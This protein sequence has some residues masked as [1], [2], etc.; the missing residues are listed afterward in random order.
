MSQAPSDSGRRP[1][2]AGQGAIPAGSG[3]EPPTLYAALDLGTNNCR[4]MIASFAHSQFRIVEAFSRIVRLGE[5]LAHSGRLQDRAM[6][7]AM[8]ALRI[9]AEKIEKRGVVRIRAVAT[10][11]CRIARN[12]RDF[13]SRVERE[14]GLKLSVISPEEEAHLS[15]M[16]CTSLLDGRDMTPA[17]RA[18]LVMDVGGGSTELSWVELNIPESRGP[19]LS[20]AATQ[21]AAQTNALKLA[22]HSPRPSHWVSIP[23]GVVNLAERFPEPETGDTAVWFEAMVAE[24]E[25]RVRQFTA[26]EVL[27]CHFDSGEA[28]IVGTS[29]AITSLAGMHLALERYD[30]AQV[31]GLWMSHSDVRAVIDRLLAL[32]RTGRELEPCIGRDRADLVLAGAAIL[33]A[34]QRLWACERLR[35]ADRGLR[36]GLLLSMAKRKSRRRRRRG[37]RSEAIAAD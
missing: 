31:D 32:G 18:A 7:R 24:V 36:E 19:V 20:A 11:A 28:Y 37:P 13:V 9:C 34:V 2:R 12:G 26:P 3:R 30:R 6:D 22:R 8:K 17:P 21:A 14:T 27:R 23:I 4:L 15:V 33:E 1:A 29:G 25:T 10:Q 5:G 35:V 16:G